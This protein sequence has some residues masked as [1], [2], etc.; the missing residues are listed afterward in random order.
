MAR[1]DTIIDEARLCYAQDVMEAGLRTDPGQC[2]AEWALN[3]Q[4]VHCIELLDGEAVTSKDSVFRRWKL[5]VFEIYSSLQRAMGS[6][7]V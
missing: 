5:E 6:I 1:N 3:C 2:I 7:V 4:Q